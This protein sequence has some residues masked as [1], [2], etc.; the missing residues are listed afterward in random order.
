M[1]QPPRQE[2]QEIPGISL[3]MNLYDVIGVRPN[4]ATI[5]LR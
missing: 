5:N 2:Q 3:S 1:M 4:E